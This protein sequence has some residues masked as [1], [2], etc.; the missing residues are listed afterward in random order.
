M[1]DTL[2]EKNVL[3]DWMIRTGIRRLLSQRIAGETKPTK[4]A[5]REHLQRYVDDLRRRPIAESTRAANEQH[6]EVPTE[7]FRFCLGRRMKYSACYFPTGAETLDEAEEAMLALYV[8]RARLADGQEILELGCGWGSLSLYLAERF[9]SARVTAVSNSTTQRAHIEER[10]R[11][12][13]LSNLRVITCDMNGF[14]AAPAAFDRVVSIE[15]FEHMKNYEQLLG[16]IAGWLKP[17]GLLFVHIF[18]HHRFAYHFEAQGPSDWMARH[19]FTGG[20]MPS[21]DLLAYFQEDLRLVQDWQVNGDHYRRTAELWL[22]NMDAHRD[23]ILPLLAD[24]YGAGHERKWW[25]YWRVF[26]M[27]C[28]ELWG[29]RDGREWLVSHY[30]FEKPEG[31]TANEPESL[32]PSCAQTDTPASNHRKIPPGSPTLG[33]FA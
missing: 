3:P 17:G 32:A 21:H 33:S 23:E 2:L 29:Y 9:P 13:G 27:S 1:I 26:F 15:M 7:F 4:D 8:E 25:A 28:A 20:Q 10:C 31:R 24:T 11:E 18:T 6:Y 14:D 30:L 22:R 12:F 16:R 19:F 5:Q